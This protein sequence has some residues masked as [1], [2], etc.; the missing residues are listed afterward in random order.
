MPK[1]VC[2]K[3]GMRLTD[4]VLRTSD[5][6]FLLWVEKALAISS[7]GRFGLSSSIQPF[8]LSINILNGFVDVESLSC[9]AVTRNGELIDVH[10]D[11]RYTNS[12]DT[13]VTIPNDTEAKEYILIVVSDKA[14][15]NETNDGMEEL[16]YS[17]AFISPETPVPDNAVPIGRIVNDYG[18]RMDDMDFVPPCLFVSAHRKYIEL[19]ERFVD[20]LAAID[21]KSRELVRSSSK[22]AV[23]IYWPVVRN[24]KIT[25]DKERDSLTPMALLGNV[26]KCISAFTCACELDDYLDLADAEAFEAY[27]RLAYNYREA[28]QT[29][30][31]GLEICS[32]IKEKVDMLQ[33]DSPIKQG[34]IK[35]PV[36][37]DD[38][39]FLNCH[40]KSVN[41]R[42]SNYSQDSIV[43][44]S[45]DGGEPARRLSR[46]GTLAIE[47]GFNKMKV[48]EPDKVVVIKLV[49]V[50]GDR[51]S[52]VSMFNVTLH[53]DFKSWEGYEI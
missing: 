28:Y 43:L 44:Y 48:P 15:W 27:V 2:W 3:K 42:V 38:Q 7:A 49:A 18:W 37:S 1:R 47:N 33:A 8:E 16:E 51:Q 13:R 19:L 22:D 29:I 30:K 31:A 52:K 25:I 24:I 26:Q 34:E 4:D 10:Y 39:L 32:S 53:K 21:V 12:F 17:F 23:R 46:L 50:E 9:Q 11:T 45:V 40:N 41:I 35:A 6:C 14:R 20:L 5:N 36:I